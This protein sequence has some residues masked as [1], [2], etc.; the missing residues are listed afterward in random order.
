MRCD[1]EYLNGRAA[2]WA[3]SF[4]FFTLFTDSAMMEVSMTPF[5]QE[6]SGRG[7]LRRAY[8]VDVRGFPQLLKGSEETRFQTAALRPNRA[9]D[10]HLVDD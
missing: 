4:A 1:S 7:A 8:S 9:A 2:N 5:L 10:G 6:N 3:R